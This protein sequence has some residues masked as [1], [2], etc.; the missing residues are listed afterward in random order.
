M[1]DAPAVEGGEGAAFAGEVMRP[2]NPSR[3]SALSWA[4]RGGNLC[5]RAEQA[6]RVC[7]ESLDPCAHR[8]GLLLEI[9]TY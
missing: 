6:L 3:Y 8:V 2:A 5:L 1:R 9:P 4:P 7:D